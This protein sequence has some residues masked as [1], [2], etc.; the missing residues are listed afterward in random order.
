MNNTR[1]RLL[2][3]LCGA[4]AAVC[5]PAAAAEPPGPARVA[6]GFSYVVAGDL[7][8][9]WRSRAAED[10]PE[11][12]RVLHIFRSADAGFA[13]LEGNLFD[14]D[15]FEGA[16]AAE[17]GGFEQGGIGSGP[18]FDVEQ[19][20]AFKDMGIT[21]I[22]LAN[23][24]SLDWGIEGLLDTMRNLEQA[25]VAHSGGGRSLVEA[26]AAGYLDTP[27]GRVA[28]VSAASTFLPMAPAG[29]GD[30][31]TR[32]APRPGISALRYTAYTRVTP[33][34]F[35]VLKGIAGRLGHEVG[36]DAT[37]VTIVP[38]DAPF[39]WQHF[40]KSD[41]YGMEYEPHPRDR[42]EILDAI[43]DARR[44]A[45]VVVFNIHAHE[46]D[47]GAGDHLVP[48]HTLQPPEFLQALMRDAVDAGADIGVVHGPH[49]LRGVEIHNGRPIFYGM[50][51]LFFEVG[52]LYDWPADWFDTMVAT[53]R[54]ASGGVREILL[55]PL[56]I[57]REHDTREGIRTGAPR[58][59]DAEEA[60][61][62]LAA[63]QE[64]SRPFGTTIE[65]RDGVGVIRLEPAPA[66]DGSGQDCGG[67]S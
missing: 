34:E 28:L 23:N 13:N 32:R 11:L 24:H 65:I 41:R 6:D 5:V 31:A 62:I 50:G 55:H 12:E 53:T 52:A 16:P 58:L 36:E 26:R 15:E 48:G 57:R 47:T 60:S 35:E 9:P 27:R 7:L 45:G 42:Q 49:T 56:R 17:N 2:G 20:A 21:T 14:L 67:E 46:S 38:N 59:A 54:F 66:C 18:R 1:I 39:T 61:R 33:E 25:G 3:A 10:D 63:L 40:R 30:A 4:F 37:E 64:A 51:S 43:R 29:P 19:A 22:G 44:E 8:G